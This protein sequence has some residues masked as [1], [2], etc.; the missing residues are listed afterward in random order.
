MKFNTQ[1]V[2]V[3][4]N[5]SNKSP[6][7][8]SNNSKPSPSKNFLSR[9]SVLSPLIFKLY[10]ASFLMTN[11]N[12]SV[13]PHNTAHPSVYILTQDKAATLLLKWIYD[14]SVPVSWLKC[15]LRTLGKLRLSAVT[16]CVCLSN[17]N[18]KAQYTH[19]HITTVDRQTYLLALTAMVVHR[20]KINWAIC[21]TL[22][23]FGSHQP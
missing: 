18:R 13:Y 3:E 11:T 20:T 7:V 19:V 4:G 12:S 22:H 6:I 15:P 10:V 8:H 14:I 2:P 17:N 21:Q 9:R 5:K 1:K 16:K 23:L